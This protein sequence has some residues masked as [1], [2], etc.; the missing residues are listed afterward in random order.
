MLPADLHLAVGGDR[1]DVGV[2]AQLRSGI[3]GRSLELGAD[4][5][6]AA[7]RHVPVARAAADHVVQEAAVLAQALVVG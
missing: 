4:A 7:D 1:D 5:P 6:H 2:G 3:A